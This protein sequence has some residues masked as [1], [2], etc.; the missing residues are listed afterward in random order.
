MDNWRDRAG[1]RHILL[2]ARDHG[3]NYDR[4]DYV[5]FRHLSRSG[6]R[7]KAGT[8]RPKAGLARRAMSRL[9][10][11]RDPV[12]ILLFGADLSARRQLHHRYIQTCTAAGR[13]KPT[14]EAFEPGHR[15]ERQISSVIA[16]QSET[17]DRRPY[18]YHSAHSGRPSGAAQAVFDS[19]AA[20]PH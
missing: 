15:R 13:I 6:A 2:A 20:R 12:V 5:H 16:R 11:D 10:A 7:R 8:E 9:S 1:D 19:G 18:G 3:G 17:K 14:M 4:A